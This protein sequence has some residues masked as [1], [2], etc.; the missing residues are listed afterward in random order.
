M[1]GSMKLSFV[2]P[3]Y[4]EERYLQDCIRSILLETAG[5]NG[6]CEIIVVNNAS[7][8]RTREL[9]LGFPEVRVIDEWR[10]G[11]THARQAG[12][13]PAQAFW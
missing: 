5:M 12:F 1:P 8:D 6:T 2:I 10:K 3:A 9:A 4:N 13:R 11:L 7:T